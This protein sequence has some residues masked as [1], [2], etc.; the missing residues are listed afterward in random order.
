MKEETI[1]IGLRITE[2]QRK[3]CEK[4]AKVLGMSI[5]QYIK[6]LIAQDMIDEKQRLWE[7]LRK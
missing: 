5:P 3:Y 6:L 1:Q 4:S 2:T 7:R